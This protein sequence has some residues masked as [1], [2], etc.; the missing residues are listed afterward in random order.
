MALSETLRHT[1]QKTQGRDIDSIASALLKSEPP[2]HIPHIDD[3]NL[4]TSA[5]LERES[6]HE[7]AAKADSSVNVL[8]KAASQVELNP[9]R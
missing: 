3:I 7:V 6:E 9:A 1:V 4:L 5:M 8:P 2:K